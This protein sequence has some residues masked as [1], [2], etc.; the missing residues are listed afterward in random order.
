MGIFDKIFNAGEDK[1]VS[2][3]ELK[4][5]L[6]GVKR[7][8]RKKQLE[9]RRLGMKQSELIGRVKRARREGNTEEVDFLYEELQQIRIDTS[10]AKREAK[11]LNLEGIGLQ[12]YLRGVE[13]LEKTSSRGRIRALM[14]RVSKSALDEKL[15]GQTVN[16]EAYLEA[17]ETTLDDVKMELED[18]AMN[19]EPDEDKMKFLNEIDEIIAAEEDGNLDAA[20]ERETQ[21]KA[22]L[23]QEAAEPEF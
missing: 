16:E 18:V 21:L 23:E 2:S 15:Q 1:V 22:E 7:E 12:R 17:L 14:E 11:V 4:V 3:R 19:D 20:V 10:Y 9:I 5:A 13:R 8:R 6:M